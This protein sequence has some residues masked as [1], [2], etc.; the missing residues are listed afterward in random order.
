MAKNDFTIKMID[1]ETFTKIAEEC[2]R[3]GQTN[4]CHRLWKVAQSPINRQIWSHWRQTSH[5][6]YEDERQISAHTDKIEEER[7]R[8][9][10]GRM[11][12]Y[13][14]SKHTYRYSKHTC[15]YS[16][17]TYRYSKHT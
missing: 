13:V 14:D 6:N 5:P 11:K 4:C 7:E 16:K 9:M 10:V 17:H 3:I 8:Y 15:R 12:K 1:F 2:G